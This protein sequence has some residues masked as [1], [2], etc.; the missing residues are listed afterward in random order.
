MDLH[1]QDRILVDL[2]LF[3][4]PIHICHICTVVR[5]PVF[6]HRIPGRISLYS[7][8]RRHM[9]IHLPVLDFHILY[10]ISR[11]LLHHMHMSILKLV[12][13]RLVPVS[14]LP[15]AVPASAV[16]A[17]PFRRA[18]A[19]YYRPFPEPYPCP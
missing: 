18:S 10:R 12:L 15:A 3:P 11:Y 6:S 7:L 9:S 19:L 13:M 14:A 17:A 8:H 5:L 16:A 4:V 1:I 2:Y